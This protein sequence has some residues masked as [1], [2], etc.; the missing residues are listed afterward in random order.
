M[1]AKKSIVG[2]TPGKGCML[3]IIVKKLNPNVPSKDINKMVGAVKKRIK[4]KGAA[5]VKKVLSEEMKGFDSLPEEDLAALV[6]D[7]IATSKCKYIPKSEG[8]WTNAIGNSKWV[9]NSDKIPG[10]ANPH[11]KTWG[12]I[13]ATYGIDG[14]EYREGEPDF[15]ILSRGTVGIEGFS[16]DRDK[17]FTKADE[18]EAKKRNC[19]PEAVYDWRK[20]NGYTWHER[21]DC[22]TM[23]K[24][25]SAVHNNMSHSGGISEKKQEI[26]LEEWL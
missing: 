18:A 10:K 5:E 20:E 17:N 26:I 6:A 12:Q 14:I 22:K 9:P 8:Y 3:H 21:R 23:D 7:L 16:Q 1:G 4:K 13:L 15:S 2:A 24:V 25:P 11:N 19:S